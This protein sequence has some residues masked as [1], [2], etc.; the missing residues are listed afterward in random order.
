MGAQEPVVKLANVEEYNSAVKPLNLIPAW[1]VMPIYAPEVPKSKCLPTV[2]HYREIRPYLLVGSKLITAKQAERRALLLHN[3]GLGDDA[4]GITQTVSGDYQI[5][6]PGEVATPIL[7][8]RP[9]PV[10]AE[11]RARMVQSEDCGDLVRYIACL[12]RRLCVNE[13]WITPTWPRTSGPTSTRLPATASTTTT[14][15][16]STT[17]TAST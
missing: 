8:K 17:S 6:L 7:D 4:H 13:A 15:A 10:S 14:T 9:N 11:D 12:P 1:L 5:M 16:T 3:P 2:W